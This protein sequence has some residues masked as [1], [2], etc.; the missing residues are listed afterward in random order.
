METQIRHTDELAIKYGV[1]ELRELLH[2]LG[3]EPDLIN[4]HILQE[5]ADNL[6]KLAGLSVDKHWTWK[7]LNQVVHNKLPA[8]RVMFEA[9]LRQGALSDGVNEAIATSQRLVSYAPIGVDV[10]PGSLILRPSR[11]CVCGLHFIPP[12]WNSKD[13]SLEC[14]K[15][16]KQ[17]ERRSVSVETGKK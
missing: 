11:Q 14:R 6:S 17:M 5:I 4:T 12:A 8:S 16:R 2:T 7:Y 3:H 10:H 13:H 9:I 15:K 1:S